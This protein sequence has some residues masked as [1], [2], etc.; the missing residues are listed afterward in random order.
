MRITIISPYSTGPVRGN[1]TTIKRITRHLEAYGVEI[2]LL[3]ADSSSTQEMLASICSFSPDVIHAFHAFHSGPIARLLAAETSKP[4]VI[5]ITGSD[6][7][8]NRYFTDRSTVEA[9]N[10]AS[11]IICF[12]EKSAERTL[13]L[14]PVSA[15]IIHIIPQGAEVLPEADIS[16]YNI[17]DSAFVLLLP[18][19]LRPV[20]K[21]EDAIYATNQAAEQIPNILLLIAGGPID[22]DY[23]DDISKLLA[24]NPYARWLGEIP[25]KQM[26]GMYRRAD[27][28]LN[29]SAY[30]EMPNSLLEA[31][32]LKKPVIAA[33]ISGNRTIVSNDTTGWLYGGD[34]Q[35]DRLIFQLHQCPDLRK[36]IGIKAGLMISQ[37]FSPALE[38]ERH[39]NL[40]KS[41][42][43]SK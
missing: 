30:E 43:C 36:N 34:K 13:S 6:I 15:E 42:Y 16:E 17:P 12:D 2:Q 41:I 22:I 1:I 20:K 11:S 10:S 25:P 4:L 27:L 28:V 38:G 24:G 3:A 33:D 23:A 37:Y 32:A 29:C 19:A 9:V 21:I 39:L 18:A 14:F 8:E 26:G 31:M 35:L 5:T 7:H 40:Y